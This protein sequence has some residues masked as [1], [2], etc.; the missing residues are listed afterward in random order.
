MSEHFAVAEL[1]CHCGCHGLIIAAELED[2][3]E[4]LRHF[5]GDKP[6]HVN[7]AYRCPKHNAEVGGVKNSYHT[8]GMAADIH[9]DG[10]SINDLALA[11]AW[12]GFSGIGKYKTFVHVDVRPKEARW[13]G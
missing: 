12:V 6:I 7:C 13:E 9:V 8:L 10:V 2:R 5:L 3:L 4:A 1:E 11:A